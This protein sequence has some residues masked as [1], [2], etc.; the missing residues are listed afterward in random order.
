[1][2]DVWVATNEN[3]TSSSA[4]PTQVF[5]CADAVAPATVP[6]V[7]N[8]HVPSLFGVT[9]VAVSQLSLVGIG[10]CGTQVVASEKAPWAV[11]EP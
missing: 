2:C 1:V 4:V 8:A 10:G 5:A 6:G 3:Q 9:F 11:P 7:V